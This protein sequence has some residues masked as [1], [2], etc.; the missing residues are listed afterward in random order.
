M[1]A[2]T[3]SFSE[4]W[5]GYRNRVHARKARRAARVTEFTST[6]EPRTIGS[7]ARGRQLVSGNLMFAGHL[8]QEKARSPWDLSPPDAA[9]EAELHGFAWLD[10]LAALGDLQA[11]KTAQ[12]WVFDWI[13][14]YSNG[15]GAGWVPDLTGRRLMRWIN[16]ALFLLSGTSKEEADWFFA[17]LAQQTTFLSRRWPVSSDGLPRFEA[18]AGTIY[19]G[20]SLNGM[21]AHVDPALKALSVQCDSQIDAQGGIITRNPEEL[22]SVFSLLNWAGLALEAAGRP[23]PE[24]QRAAVERIAPTLRALRH[25]DGGLARFHGGGRGAEGRL[26]QALADSGVRGKRSAELAMGYA[27]LSGGRTSVVIDSAAPPQGRASR[28]AHASTL[29]FEMTSGRRPVIVNCGSGVQFG[30]EW[31]RAGRATPMHST[32]VLDNSSSSHLGAAEQADWLVEVPQDVPWEI[33]PVTDG[34]QYRGGHDGYVARYGL[35]HARMIEVSTDG[36][37]VVGEDMLVALR[38]RDK[39]QVEAAMTGALG[40]L[41]FEVRFHIHPD[42]ESTLD[43]GGTAISLALKSGE[44]WVFRSGGGSS[45]SLEASVYLEKGRL[46]PRAARQIVLSGTAKASATR[47]RWSLAK[48]KDTP[49]GLRDITPDPLDIDQ[50]DD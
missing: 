28:S 3:P 10:D 41:P 46:K 39:A 9:F 16:H 45:M 29:A 38:D 26:D 12:R 36:R 5:I 1:S 42:V 19:A 49:T 8:V 15:R 7:F 22:L 44:I 2:E 6:P 24:A 43:M 31:A 40:G 34:V 27:R 11:R 37:A 17:S 35:T 18:L 20:L 30:E 32:L 25:A 4:R 48:A 33:S 50:T 23:V 21:E 13:A 14:R 47:I